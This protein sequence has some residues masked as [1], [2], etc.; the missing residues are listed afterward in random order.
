MTIFIALDDCLKEVYDS[1]FIKR[2]SGIRAFL[3]L[4]ITWGQSGNLFKLAA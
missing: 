1:Q 2:T 3:I 4:E